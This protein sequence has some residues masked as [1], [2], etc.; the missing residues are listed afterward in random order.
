MHGKK[1][2]KAIRCGCG[3]AGE[4]FIHGKEARKRTI[5]GNRMQVQ[6][7]NSVP[8]VAGYLCFEALYFLLT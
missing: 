1:A 2:N 7:C 4:W 3:R 6:K 5:K 8:G